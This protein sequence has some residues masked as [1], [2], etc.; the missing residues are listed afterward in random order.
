LSLLPLADL[1]QIIH[2]KVAEQSI[3][4]RYLAYNDDAQDGTQNNVRGL[5]TFAAV[6]SEN[7]MF[8]GQFAQN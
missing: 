3:H 8:L 1:F 6:I 7:E 4:N 5:S 2:E